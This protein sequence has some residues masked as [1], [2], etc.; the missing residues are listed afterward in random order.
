MRLILVILLLGTFSLKAQDVFVTQKFNNPLFVNPALTGNGD[1]LNRLSL[2]Y[3]DQWRS[4]AVPYS[5]SYIAYDRQILR[6]NNNLVSGGILFFYDKTGDGALSTFNPSLSVAYTKFFKQERF[7]LSAG[8]NLGYLQNTVNPNAFQFDNQFGPNGYDANISAGETIDKGGFVSLGVGINLKTRIYGR[9][10][11]DIGFA[12]SNPHKPTYSFS[13]F[14]GDTRP[15]RYSTQLSGEL[16]IVDQISL[17]PSFHFQGQEKAKE[18]HTSL[19]LNYYTKSVKV[20]IKLSLGGGYRTQDA[21]LTYIGAKIKDIQLGFSYDINTS[22]FTDA[23]NKKGGFEVSLV[24]EFERKK[25]KIVELDTVDKEEHLIVEK[26]D[27]VIEILV[28]DTVEIIEDTIETIVEVIEPLIETPKEIE[29]PVEIVTPVFDK[30]NVIKRVLPVQLYFDNDQPNPKTYSSVTS[31]NYGSSYSQYMLRKNDYERKIGTAITVDWF[32]QV[33][34]SKN[35]LDK[36]IEYIKSLTDN[37]YKIE[38]TLKGY[39]SP[40][41]SSKYNDALASRRIESVLLYLKQADNGLLQNAFQDGKL[42]VT[43]EPIGE[44]NSPAEIS[45][46][47]T[48][49][50]QSVYSISAAY[51]RRVEIIAVDIVK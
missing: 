46:N 12:V 7:A 26:E 17:S 2:L 48:N 4:A 38:I 1:K 47:G 29:K 15:V 32:S 35:D 43:V 37:G 5:S 23:T 6:S 28:K 42:I 39:T 49:K 10:T 3:R 41:A 19:L 8:L 16:F 21:A 45:D 36:A 20:P 50:Q 24:Y 40:L 27:S 22:A 9:S 33:T 51:E 31:V 13:S 44:N 25:E 18:F 34:Q 30:I 14:I 11:I